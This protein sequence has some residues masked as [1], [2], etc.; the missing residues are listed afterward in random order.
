[1]ACCCGPANQCGCPLDSF[2]PPAQ[3]T[4]AMTAS[5]SNTN[6]PLIFTICPCIESGVLPFFNTT[7]TANLILDTFLPNDRLVTYRYLDTI[8]KYDGTQCNFGV[9]G[10]SSLTMSMQF[11]VSCL[12][13]NNFSVGMAFQGRFVFNGC[14]ACNCSIGGF[15][16]DINFLLSETSLV[17]PFPGGLKNFCPNESGT[18]SYNSNAQL[19]MGGSDS[20]GWGGGGGSTIGP[21]SFSVT[22]S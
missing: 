3:A 11:G 4:V 10:A 2:S 7:I 1:M 9:V 17:G 12:G 20:I 16:R 19:R 18:L 21:G 22:F 5:V 14:N 6:R 8:N 13:R 15:G